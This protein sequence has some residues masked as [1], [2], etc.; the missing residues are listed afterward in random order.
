MNLRIPF[1]CFQIV[2]NPCEAA[3][4]IIKIDCHISMMSYIIFWIQV[5]YFVINWIDFD[6]QM[7]TFLGKFIKNSY[8]NTIKSLLI[9]GFFS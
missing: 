2:S 8:L 1:E 3:Q 9:L 4:R 7:P 6:K 5:D